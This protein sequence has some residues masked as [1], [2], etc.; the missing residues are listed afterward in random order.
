[1]VWRLIV[2]VAA[3]LANRIFKDAWHMRDDAVERGDRGESHEDFYEGL[4][5]SHATLTRTLLSSSNFYHLNLQ[6]MD[7]AHRLVNHL[8]RLDRLPPNNSLE[9]LLLLRSAWRDYDVAMLMASRYKRSCKVGQVLCSPAVH[10][11]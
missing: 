11:Y 8:V 10:V 6:D 4:S 3:W 2:E 5:F 7:G 9:G 1:M